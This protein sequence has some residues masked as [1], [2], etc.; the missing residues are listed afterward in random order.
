MVDDTLIIFRGSSF[1]HFSDVHKIQK[2]TLPARFMTNKNLFNL[3]RKKSLT[4]IQ[5]FKNLFLQTVIIT[6]IGIFGE[7]ESG[8]F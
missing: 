1:F 3:P 5:H 7:L 2:K 4:K 8:K 6:D